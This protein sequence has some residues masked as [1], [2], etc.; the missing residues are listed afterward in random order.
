ML[1]IDSNFGL[2]LLLFFIIDRYNPLFQVIWDSLSSINIIRVWIPY[3]VRDGNMDWKLST[4]ILDC[5][6]MEL[7][8][9][10]PVLF[11]NA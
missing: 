5:S 10:T 8:E 11:D 9:N 2:N 3:Q 6:G 1:V 7:R 4:W